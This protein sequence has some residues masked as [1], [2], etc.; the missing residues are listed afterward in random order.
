MKPIRDKMKNPSWEEL[1]HK[2][3]AEF[4]NLCA[5]APYKP[6]VYPQYQIYAVCAAEV[7]VDILTGQHQILRFDVI[8]DVGDS[9]NPTIDIG[10]LEGAIVMGIGYY[11]TENII[12]DENGQILTNRTWNY[13]VPGPKDIPIDFRIKFPK[14]NPN[15]V[16]VLNSK[17]IAEPPICLTFAV[18]LAIRDAVSSARLDADA[19][20]P[21]WYPVSKYYECIKNLIKPTVY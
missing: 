17:A 12:M 7:E 9:M 14:D 15:P 16:G 20:K 10:Q 19:T 5:T 8:E 2:C 4:V 18:P 11:T 1:I 21:K 6:G 13:Y 3:A